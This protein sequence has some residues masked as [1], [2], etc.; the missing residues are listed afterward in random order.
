MSSLRPAVAV[1]AIVMAMPALAAADLTLGVLGYREATANEAAW[2]PIEH[3]LQQRLPN[4]NVHV[5]LFDYASLHE[6]IESREVDLLATNPAEYV[7]LS[8]QGLVTSPLVS[9]V[10]EEHGLR[11]RGFGGAIV[12]RSDRADLRTLEDLAGKRIA[13]VSPQSLGGYIAQAYELQAAGVPLPDARRTLRTS[14]PHEE[15]LRAVLENRADAA[16]V[17]GGVLEAMLR[18]GRVPRGALEVLN[19]Q[20]LPGYPYAVSTRLYPEWPIAALH[21][22]DP[23]DAAA[24]A[25]ALLDMPHE[26]EVAAPPGI[27]GFE[28]PFNYEPV[29]D[30]LRELRLPPYDVLPAI[31]FADVWREHRSP[32][33][34]LF[35][36][37]DAV[38]LLL[39]TVVVSMIRRREQHRLIQSVFAQAA[40]GIVVID[41]ITMR[42]VDFNDAACRVLGYDREEFSALTLGTILDPGDG[43]RIAGWRDGM[44]EAGSIAGEVVHRRRDGSRC[45]IDMRARQLVVAGR[46]YWVAVWHD[47]TERNRLHA[48]LSHDRQRLHDIIGATRAG[49]WEW[50]YRSGACTFNER[51]AE[52]LGY[53]LDELAPASVDTWQGLV[54][55]DDRQRTDEILQAHLTGRTQFYECEM[56]M[57]HKSGAWMWISDR[58]RV[59]SRDDEGRPLVLSGTHVDVTERRQAEDLLRQSEQRFRNIAEGTADCLWA[60]D[61]DG[62]RIYTNRAGTELLGYTPAELDQMSEAEL[63]HPDD[64]ALYRATFERA[65]D[66]QRGWRGVVLRWICRD[67]TVRAMES[68]ATP[69]FDAGGRLTGFQGIDRDIT[70]KTRIATELEAYRHHLEE[71]VQSR[72]LELEQAKEAAEVANRA[73]SVFLANMSHEIRTPMNAIIG[74][75]HLLQHDLAEPRHLDRVRKISSSARHLLAILNDILDLSKIEAESLGIESVPFSVTQV[76]DHVQ[77]MIGHRA[78][79]KRLE[80]RTEIEP[81]LA[82]LPLAG[83]PFR[84]GQVLVNYLSNAIKFTDRGVIR[85]GAAI[86]AEEDTGLL[87]RFEVEDTG[88]GLTPEQESRIFEAFEQ[89]SES[90]Q[91][92]YGG[93]GLG[94]AISRRLA[95][96][97][98]GETGVSSRYGIGSTFWFTVRVARG[99]GPIAAPEATSVGRH[100]AGIVL[101]VEDNEINREVIRDLLHDVGLRVV[102][103]EHGREAVDK[104][105]EA[106][107]DLILMD[108]QMPVMNGVEATTVIRTLPHGRDVP[109]IAITANA[110]AED[111]QKCLDAGMNDHVVKPIDPDFLYASLARW[112]PST[113]LPGEDVAPPPRPAEDDAATAPVLDVAAGLRNLAGRRDTY[114]RMLA[115]FSELHLDDAEAIRAALAAGRHDDAERLA[116]TLKGAAATMGLRRLALLAQDMERALKSGAGADEVPARLTTLASG[117]AEAKRAIAEAATAGPA[118]LPAPAPDAATARRALADLERWLES[119]DLRAGEAWTA[120][121]VVIAAGHGAESEARIGRLIEAFEFPAALAALRELGPLAAHE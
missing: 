15:A 46:E 86:A 54:H 52:M 98:G 81:A 27:H 87:L 88:V 73:K 116:H 13:I 2:K 53:S 76:V 63:V 83:D 105:R 74:L 37:V 41:P 12:V 11:L 107:F 69:N 42:L 26:P 104:V 14:L 94:L 58:G 50:D 117:V 84:I 35:V 38:L 43:S 62:R 7:M 49:T 90:T 96:L 110:F 55:P 109:I 21:H 106:H 102:M 77:S 103:A 20:N 10:S 93:T 85:L 23:A 31:T 118:P 112:L 51:W 67:G 56:R 3:Y 101:L 17:R 113:V 59:T 4:R 39:V 91:R 61:A 80:L 95:H 60:I 78:T 9:I 16:F 115:R 72:T 1:L 108:M 19:R 44:A 71:L 68:N 18:E 99:T 47:V 66:E 114:F 45:D 28:I 40:E 111:R 34:A 24:V 70:E 48:L 8:A 36:A 65:R 75:A 119:D 120:A 29:R 22:V 121:R 25:A 6:A 79:E 97:M 33:I 92:K 32:M 64:L 89:G 100:Y 30:A 57:R 5:T 82:T